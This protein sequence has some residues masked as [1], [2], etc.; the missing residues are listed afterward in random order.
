M[1]TTP[2]VTHFSFQRESNFAPGR[3]GVATFPVKVPHKS[4]QLQH[5]HLYLLGIFPSLIIIDHFTELV[6]LKKQWQ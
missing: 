5:N 1:C 4:A 6:H 2:K 3:V